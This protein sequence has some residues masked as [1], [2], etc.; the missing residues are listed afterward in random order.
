MIRKKCPRTCS[1]GGTGFRIRSPKQG[2]GD[3]PDS[4]KLDQTL[5]ARPRGLLAARGSAL[6]TADPCTRPCTVRSG[7]L[8]AVSVDHRRW[9]HTVFEGQRCAGA[10]LAARMYGASTA[11]RA[12]CA[13]FF[14]VYAARCGPDADLAIHA[15]EIK[16]SPYAVHHNAAT[17][18][19]IGSL[20]FKSRR[21]FAFLLC[22]HFLL[23]LGSWQGRHQRR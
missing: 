9:W 1:G 2:E 16:R 12:G 11:R 7:Q 23:W 6:T 4:A 8:E 18:P 20:A 14:S 15:A 17:G 5:A 3:G 22:S 10:P 21:R 19:S 13:H